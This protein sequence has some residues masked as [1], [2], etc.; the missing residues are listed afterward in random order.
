MTGG[1]ERK[2]AYR[3]D[4]AVFGGMR[5][6]IR[7]KVSGTMCAHQR[8][9]MMEG[10]MVLTDQAMRCPAREGQGAFRSPSLTHSDD[11][12]VKAANDR[13]VADSSGAA[14]REKWPG[15]ETGTGVG[16]SGEKPRR[17]R[18]RKDAGAADAERKTGTRK[19]GR[20][21]AEGRREQAG[22]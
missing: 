8:M 6:P 4:Q 15:K 10:R 17:G 21:P 7:C 19:A 3:C 13:A 18:P 11:G 5:E 14:V 16:G 20:K 2:M 1:K 22:A 12:R 9:C